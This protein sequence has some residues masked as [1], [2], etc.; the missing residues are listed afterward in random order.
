MLG[1]FCNLKC[2]LN[3]ALSLQ[4]ILLLNLLI[5]HTGLIQ[6]FYNGLNFLVQIVQFFTP[7]LC[8]VKK[9]GKNVELTNF[10]RPWAHLQI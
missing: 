9:F 4:K 8:D 3:L 10:A 6:S 1:S 5:C 7:S 2:I